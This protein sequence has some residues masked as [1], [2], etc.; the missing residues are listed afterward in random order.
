MS[1]DLNKIKLRLNKLQ[2]NTSSKSVMWRPE[3]GKQVIR[4]VPYKFN[5]SNPFFEGLF[6]YNMGP[7]T[8]LSPST[9]SESD[10]VIEFA[11]NLKRTGETED[12][13]AAKRMEPKLRTYVPVIV[14][15]E[16]NEGVRFWGFGKTVYQELLAV[17]ADPDY[18]DITDPMSGRDITLEYIS[19]DEAGKSYPETRLR[20]KPNQTPLHEDDAKAKSWLDDQQKIEE[21]WNVPS[22][23]EMNDMLKSWLEGTTDDGD[24]E[25][26]SDSGSSGFKLNQSDDSSS[27]TSPTDK[28]YNEPKEKVSTKSVERASAVDQV[29]KDFDALFSG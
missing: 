28:V 4:I 20:V 2:N 17:I 25:G 22:Y 14:R 27:K 26:E 15:D 24:G 8:I 18:G 3:V 19:A 6:Y 1:I 13:R 16:E 5:P 7:R 23:D 10:P 21:I 11:N 29:T 12:W 9:F